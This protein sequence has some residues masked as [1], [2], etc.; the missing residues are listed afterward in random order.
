MF[1]YAEHIYFFNAYIKGIGYFDFNFSKL[2]VLY[3]IYNLNSPQV[4][5]ISLKCVASRIMRLNTRGLLNICTFL[6]N[7]IYLFIA[8]T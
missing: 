4:S 1:K 2:L 8:F 7:V 5:S 6:L 3:C